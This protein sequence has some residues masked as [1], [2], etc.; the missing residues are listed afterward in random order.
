VTIKPEQ[1][2]SETSPGSGGIA[3]ALRGDAMSDERRRSGPV[4]KAYRPLVDQ[5]VLRLTAR[6]QSNPQDGNAVREL[7]EHYAAHGDLPSLAN[8]LQGWANAVT[9]DRAAADAYVEAGDVVL[10]GLAD[11]ARAE[12]LYTRALKR[13][14]QHAPALAKLERLLRDRGD[15]IGLARCLHQLATAL[16]SRATARPRVRADIHFRLAR[17]Y[18]QR[19]R[20]LDAAIVQYRLAIEADATFS[21]AITAAYALYLAQD[22]AA[23]AAQMLELQIAAASDATERHGLLLTLARHCREACKDLDATVHALQRAVELVR[24]DAPTL[25]WL[26]DLLR[27][28]AERDC[29]HADWAAAADCW[30]QA[31]RC[32]LRSEAPARLVACLAMRPDH[33]RARRMRAELEAYGAQPDAAPLH[34]QRSQAEIDAEPTGLFA[35]PAAAPVQPPPAAAARPE[36][37]T[38][39]S[40][41]VVPPK[42]VVARAAQSDDGS[43]WLDEA[44]FTLL[45]EED[46]SGKRA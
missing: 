19:L 1:H 35:L 44:D 17:H 32:V 39:P 38:S 23:G 28:R 24:A 40:L 33:W 31:A 10:A 9:Q 34:A 2:E 30:Y 21:A 8:L 11:S 43:D 14:P 42:V 13:D 16:A 4:P 41:K 15:D 3:S 7:K 6:I 46:Q 45:D 36:P 27:E 22:D 12:S 5:R 18:Q 20:D 37:T 25:E 29:S 26:A